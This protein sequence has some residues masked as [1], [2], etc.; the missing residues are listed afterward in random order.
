M[1]IQATTSNKVHIIFVYTVKEQRIGSLLQ[2]LS[3][4]QLLW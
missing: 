4:L 2:H 1:H 3:N